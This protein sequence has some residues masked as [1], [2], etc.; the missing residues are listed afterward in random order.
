VLAMKR[1][2]LDLV[3]IVFCKSLISRLM[4][5]DPRIDP[6]RTQCFISPCNHTDMTELFEE[7]KL[8]KLLRLLRLR[9]FR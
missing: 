6:S 9:E 1:R 3:C 8:H 4:S 2:G 7:G 5:K